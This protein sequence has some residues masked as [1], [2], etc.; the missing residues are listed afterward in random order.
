MAWN[1]FGTDEAIG[2]L[3]NDVEAERARD[4]G[5]PWTFAVR[6]APGDEGPGLEDDGHHDDHRDAQL[7]ALSQ[8]H[9]QVTIL[10][11]KVDV[12]EGDEPLK[13]DLFVY[14][15]GRRHLTKSVSF[16]RDR[17]RRMK[18]LV[19]LTYRIEQQLRHKYAAINVEAP[20]P[21]AAP[22]SLSSRTSTS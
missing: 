11:A 15:K 4:P 5:F 7:L 12:D 21:P 2:A 10:G 20:S 1:V 17:D 22:T 18:K 14:A 16:D 13:V 9:P 6:T 3:A 19:S 8:R